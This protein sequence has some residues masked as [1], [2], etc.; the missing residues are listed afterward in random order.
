[1]SWKTRMNFLA[2][3]IL[4]RD[5][6]GPW[7]EGFYFSGSFPCLT[8]VTRAPFLSQCW[9]S[10]GTRNHSL[11]LVSSGQG[12]IMA[13]YVTS[14][15][16]FYCAL[17]VSLTLFTHLQ[18]VHS[19]SSLNSS[20]RAT[21]YFL[22]WSWVIMSLFFHSYLW[23]NKENHIHFWPANIA[24]WYFLSYTCCTKF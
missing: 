18:V 15:G 1:M 21:I 7:G 13:P 3:P 16:V 10:R 19:L 9:Q 14:L 22:C 12:V 4:L 2:N 6:Q 5:Q 11:P 20:C 17:L 23:L 24:Y 8:K